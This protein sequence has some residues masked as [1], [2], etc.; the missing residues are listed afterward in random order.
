MSHPYRTKTQGGDRFSRNRP[1]LAK[2]HYLRLADLT[3]SPKNYLYRVGIVLKISSRS[4]SIKSYSTFSKEQITCPH[5][6]IGMSEK[7]IF[8]PF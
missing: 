1:F 4:R 8:M 5:I 7:E 3:P 2:G 6:H